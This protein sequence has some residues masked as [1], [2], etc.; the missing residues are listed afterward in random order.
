MA[1]II[2]LAVELNFLNQAQNMIVDQAGHPFSNLFLAFLRKK[3]ICT[4]VIQ[5]PNIIAKNVGGITDMFLMMD[6]NLQENDIAIM[7]FA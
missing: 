4:L 2:V 5:E 3:K 1:L 7:V 6:Q